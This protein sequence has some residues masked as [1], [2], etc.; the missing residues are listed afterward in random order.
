[1]F[2]LRIA[3]EAHGRAGARIGITIAG[4]ELGTLTNGQSMIIL[5]VDLTVRMW[6]GSRSGRSHDESGKRERERE[7]VRG[8]RVRRGEDQTERRKRERERTREEG[9]RMEVTQGG[10][11][12]R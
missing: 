5:R 4:V 6:S 7:R 3:L 11:E 2:V 12:I 9:R 10:A 8:V 1:M